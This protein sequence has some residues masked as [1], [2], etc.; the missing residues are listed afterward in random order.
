[1]QRHAVFGAVSSAI[2]E[3]GFAEDG[4]AG[5]FG[6][7]FD[8]EE[9]GMSDCAFDAN[10]DGGRG[11]SICAGWLGL[12]MIFELDRWKESGAAT[13]T[14]GEGLLIRAQTPAVVIVAL[15]V[16]IYV[17]EAQSK[18]DASDEGEG[19]GGGGVC[20][21]MVRDGHAVYIRGAITTWK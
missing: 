4:A 8:L 9:L 5:G 16:G 19:E 18:A 13:F 12:G 6:E 10:G 17:F 15:Q 1:M 7:R 11:G 21:R 14:F 2:E 3:F 20:L